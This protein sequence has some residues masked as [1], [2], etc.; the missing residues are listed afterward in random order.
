MAPPR[1]RTTRVGELLRAGREALSLTQDAL[2]SR[3]FVSTR[4]VSRW[5]NGASPSEDERIRLFNA[6][7]TGPDAVVAALADALDIDIEIKGEAVQPPPSPAR[8]PTARTSAE[9]RASLDAIIL[10]VAE[11]RNLLPR[12]LRAFA[13]AILQGVD[14]LGLSARE[15]AVLVAPA[16]G[17]DRGKGAG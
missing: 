17:A 13:V 14:R 3:V 16:K 10:A 9:L 6:L 2:A 12:H 1:K 5:E 4:Q 7:A 11:E 8:S 15:A